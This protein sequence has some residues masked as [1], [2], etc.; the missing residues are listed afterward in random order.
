VGKGLTPAAAVVA[1][2]CL[3]A[4]S[5]WLGR[6]HAAA[7]GPPAAPPD[8]ILIS[9]DT[10]RADH[11]G[12]YGYPHPTSP[13]LDRFR[14]DAVLFS[15]AIA[16]APSTLPSHASLMTSLWPRQHGAMHTTNRPLAARFLTLAEVF[17]RHGYRTVSFN[18]GGQLAPE[19]GLGNGFDLYRSSPIGLADLNGSSLTGFRPRFSYITGQA[20]AWRDANPRPPLFL[21]L[22]TYQTHHPYRPE[23][24][25]LALM[26]PP[27][28]GP[29]PATLIDV[30]TLVAINHK[31]R[32]MS[33]R[34]LAHIVAA[35]DA[36][37][38]AMDEAF[39]AYMAYLRRSGRYDAA[40]VVVTSDHGEELGDHG[41]VGWHANTLYDE[42]L[43][44]PLLI[45]L[46]YGVHAGET[47]ASQVR[48]ID[49][50]PTLLA[51]MGW[52][53]PAQFHGADLTPYLQDRALDPRVAVSQID[54]KP[55]TAIRTAAWKLYDGRLYDLAGDP[56]E[57]RDVAAQHPEVAA[58]LARELRAEM[59]S[60][61]AAAA[62]PPGG[63]VQLSR[64]ERA[65][66]RALGYL[67]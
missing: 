16:A 20:A 21:F 57:S 6:A 12:C 60:G 47:V 1:A 10:L 66:L 18:D 33:P 4:G 61:P 34:D 17:R 44:V 49:V 41:Q 58:K 56:G 26:E 45:K 11:L 40:L 65:R 29:L 37:I 62:P 3:A 46:P 13:N 19:F 2:V 50:A 14:D 32:P 48:N 43:R 28:H 23:P 15:Q 9:I 24:R 52:P 7:P 8:V 27:Y 64:E 5:L 38:R 22:H 59:A 36:G 25:L 53:R 31:Q 30:P 42:L 35:Y 67:P 39:G 63:D 54:S 51:A 55:D